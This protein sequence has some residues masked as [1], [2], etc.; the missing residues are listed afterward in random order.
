MPTAAS[1]TSG[2]RR[3]AADVRHLLWFRAQQVRRG[4]A[5]RWIAVAFVGLTLGAAVVPAFMPGAGAGEGRSFEILL[6]LPT[7]M[8]GFLV[9]AGVSAVAS[10]GGR[11][12]LARDPAQIHPVS[13]TTDHLGALLLAPLNI[14]WLLQAWT[15]L[16]ATAYSLGT[17][18]L[19]PAQIVLLL[20]LAA[21]TALAQVVAWCLEGV[22]RLTHGIA[23]VRLVMVAALGA[24]LLLQMNGLLVP[25]LDRIPTTWMVVGMVSDWSWRWAV[26]A[27][28]V[29][30]R[31]DRCDR[32]RRGAGA[33]RRPAYPPRRAARRD[34][35]LHRPST[36]ALRSR[37]PG[38]HRPCVG[39]ACR[40]D[41]PR[42]RRARDRPGRGRGPGQP[43]VEL[44]DDP[45]RPG[46]LRRR[47]AVRRERVVPRRARLAVAREPAGAAGCGV[48][49]PRLRARRVPARRLDAHPGAGRD[50]RRPAVAG[51]ADGAALH[52]GRGHPPGGGG[53]AALVRPA[54]VR[55]GPSLGARHAR[56]AADHGRVLDPPRDH[57]HPD[58]AGVLRPR[59]ACRTGRS[60]WWSRCR[61]CA[62]RPPGCC[63][64]AAPGSTPATGPGS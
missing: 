21:A 29:L 19:A 24:A 34:R 38:P 63:A 46:R 11:E 60:A 6:L 57:H 42:P 3:A 30:G 45:A 62:G 37:G 8:T 40:P 4:R 49:G 10:G 53:R 15:L 58:R 32:T 47:A 22:R 51:R 64:P 43:A 25:A 56:P 41:A 50:P 55:R 44:D 13:P 23:A 35:H 12:L 1:S 7:L 16:G 5:A 9:L 27:L 33:L 2:A 18:S 52:P 17:N 28:V 20:W 39:L 48:H 31:A 59:A 61:S 54:A 14:A 26:T 36:A